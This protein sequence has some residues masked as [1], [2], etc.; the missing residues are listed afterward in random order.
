M[1]CVSVQGCHETMCVNQ[2]MESFYLQI[3]NVCTGW[4]PTRVTP[5]CELLGIT[6]NSSVSLF[7]N[8]LGLMD[9]HVGQP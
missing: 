8:E 2:V 7:K 4:V 6:E 3:A 1:V 9:G 5:M